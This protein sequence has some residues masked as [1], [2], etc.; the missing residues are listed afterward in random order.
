MFL[1][2]SFGFGTLRSHV[3]A[4]TAPIATGRHT[5]V[6]PRR[7]PVG[8]CDPAKV[9]SA[10]TYALRFDERGQPRRLGPMLEVALALLGEQLAAQLERS[11]FVVCQRPPR[12]PHST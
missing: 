7:N 9:A 8:P 12:P 1:I 11:N 4:A 10:L 6:R 5:R 2:R 3:R